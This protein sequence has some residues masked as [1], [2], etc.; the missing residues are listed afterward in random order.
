MTRR[1]LTGGLLLALVALLATSAHLWRDRRAA[2]DPAGAVTAARLAASAFFTLDHRDV[3]ADLDRMLELT[4][5][6]FRTSY[7]EQR[8]ALAAGVEEKGLVVTAEVPESGVA[9]EFFDGSTAEVLVAVDTT[10]EAGGASEEQRYRTRVSL[11]RVDDAWLV[12]G[13]EQVG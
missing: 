3:E 11:T 4:T 2:D 5:G 13:V 9:V 12:S 10:T 1:L 8:D 6:E 7:A